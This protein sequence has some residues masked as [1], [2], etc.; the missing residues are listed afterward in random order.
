MLR[1]LTAGESH[2]P[3]LVTI[4]EGLPAGLE[5]SP[6]GNATPGVALTSTNLVDGV[7][8]T[9]V[10]VLDFDND[11]VGVFVN[12][13]GGDFW[14]PDTGN[15]SADASLVYDGDNWSSSVRLASGGRT[16]WD[17]LTVVLDDPTEV[18]LIPE[19]SVG[20]LAALTGL[21]LLRRRR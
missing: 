13:T 3:G 16:N 10:G 14:N 21:C 6:G 11:L 1:F 2:G 5:I 12:P 8:A 15:N 20:L 18:G 4:V 19:P 9:M 17:N 7:T